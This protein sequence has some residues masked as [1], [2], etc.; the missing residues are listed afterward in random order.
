MS[1]RLENIQTG[2]VD[3][4]RAAE[5]LNQNFLQ[6]TKIR[7]EEEDRQRRI[8]QEEDARLASGAQL[9]AG[10]IDEVDKME[11]GLDENSRLKLV[12]RFNEVKSGYRGLQEAISKGVKVGT[13]QYYELYNQ[14]NV[15]KKSVLDQI[16]VIKQINESI[17]SVVKARAAGFVVKP[18][19]ESNIITLKE[20][21]LN[22]Q[23]KPSTGLIT[24]QDVAMNS[25]KPATS[26]IKAISASLPTNVSLDV[27]YDKDG[28]KETKTQRNIPLYGASMASIEYN[29]T[30]LPPRDVADISNKLS[31]WKNSNA[32]DSYAYKRYLAYMNTDLVQKDSFKPIIKSPKDFDEKDYVLM[33]SLNSKFNLNAK[34]TE[35]FITTSQKKNYDSE[36]I[37]KDFMS[38]LFSGDPKQENEV[39][40]NFSGGL[41]SRGFIIARG[42]RVTTKDGVEFNPNPNG[43][44]IQI[45]KVADDYDTGTTTYLNLKGGTADKATALDFINRF[46]SAIG[47]PGRPIIRQK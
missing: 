34:E 2:F 46:N 12:E 21:V 24:P 17:D 47:K 9:Y 19:I 39:L 10:W 4:G 26:T 28:K 36:I 45:T 1:R 44:D 37:T 29:L 16:G 6:A 15:K 31:A 43:K 35:K 20:S 22:G 18:E 7:L 27:D 30:N 5:N 41:A 3:Y 13:P 38:K 33:E 25:Y 11:N 23:W 8:Q 42:T 40:D 32:E 14:I